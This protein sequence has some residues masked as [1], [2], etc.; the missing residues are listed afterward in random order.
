MTILAGI[1]GKRY[2]L[3]GLCDGLHVYETCNSFFFLV[4]G[5]FML[6]LNMMKNNVFHIIC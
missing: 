6:S 5:V 1:F 4:S 2:F 3:S